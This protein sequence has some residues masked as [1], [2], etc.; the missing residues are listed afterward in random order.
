MANLNKVMLIGRL[1]RDPEAKVFEGGKVVSFGFSGNNKKRNA[2]SG[3]MRSAHYL[4]A[5]RCLVA[6][7]IPQPMEADEPFADIVFDRGNTYSLDLA[8]KPPSGS[9]DARP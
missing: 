2:Q 4:P 3:T 9:E 7:E 8:L 1:T 6:V 5:Y